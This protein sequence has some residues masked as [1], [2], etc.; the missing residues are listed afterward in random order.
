MPK[1]VAKNSFVCLDP[2]VYE[3][4]GDS[5]LKERESRMG[6]VCQSDESVVELPMCGR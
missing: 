2:Y 6:V 1:S 4:Q 3:V 5:E